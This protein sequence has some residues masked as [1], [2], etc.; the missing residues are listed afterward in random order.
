MNKKNN[1]IFIAILFSF[2]TFA[3]KKSDL[4]HFVDSL[5]Q[6]ESK[7]LQT[8]Q[9]MSVQKGTNIPFS[10]IIFINGIERDKDNLN[11]LTLDLVTDINIWK[12]ESS[13][14]RFGDK[15]KSGVIDL[16]TI[17]TQTQYANPLSVRYFDNQNA[18]STE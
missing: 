8:S 1:L 15:G 3:Q 10:P 6:F 9:R 5:I 4:Y 18:I 16:Y 7:L 11:I 13:L 12:G 14:M 2:Q 17:R